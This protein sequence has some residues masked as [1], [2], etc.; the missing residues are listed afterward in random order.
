MTPYME[1]SRAAARNN[2]IFR[3]NRSVLVDAFRLV[4]SRSRLT[5]AT[6]AADAIG[7]IDQ[8][9]RFLTS[10]IRIHAKR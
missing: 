10:E 2:L 8:E 1:L 3:K 5:L 7:R 6:L 9:A 4:I